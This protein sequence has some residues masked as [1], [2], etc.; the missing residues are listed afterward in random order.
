MNDMNRSGYWGPDDTW[1][2]ISWRGAVASAMRGKR[3]QKFLREMLEALDAMPI[4]K[5]VA[6]DLIT[7]NGETCA[8]GS[9]G[10]A[11]GMDMDGIDPYDS[12]KV[13][14]MFGIAEAMVCEIA[15]VNDEEGLSL[16]AETPED[17]WSR[18]R[19]WVV[20]NISHET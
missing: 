19:R 18:V 14:S 12:T 17:R 16:K 15:Y 10:L 6:E 20:R 3:G 5:L 2:A 1:A 9:V 7:L 4:K 8:I 11:R 13:A